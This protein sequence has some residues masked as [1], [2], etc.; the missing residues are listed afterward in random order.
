[1]IDA[2]N[3]ANLKTLPDSLAVIG[4]GVISV[5]YATVRFVALRSLWCGVWCVGCVVYFARYLSAYPRR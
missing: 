3:M 4:G 5:E 2:T 1:M